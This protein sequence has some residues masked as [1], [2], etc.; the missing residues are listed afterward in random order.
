MRAASGDWACDY[1]TYTLGFER[2]GRR[3][4]DRGPYVKVWK[5][6]GSDWKI[7]LEI[8]NSSLAPPSK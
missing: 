2:E 6:N 7:A 3:I 4:Q 8:L 5:K 1:S